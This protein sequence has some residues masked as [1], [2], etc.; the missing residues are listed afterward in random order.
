MVRCSAWCWRLCWYV[1]EQTKA[2]FFIV[3]PADLA[4]FGEGDDDVSASLCQIT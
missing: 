1:S 3:S 4:F 2:T